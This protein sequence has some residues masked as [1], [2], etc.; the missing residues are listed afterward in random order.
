MSAAGV[1]EAVTKLF[2]NAV[3][4]AKVEIALLAFEELESDRQATRQ[5][6]ALQL[7]RADYEVELARRRYEAADPENRLVA[8]ELEAHWEAALHQREQ[9]R[10][11]REDFERRESQ[12]LSASDRQHIQELSTDLGRVWHAPTT[13]MEERKT[14]LRFLVQRVHLDGVTKP[15]HIRIDVQ[16]HTGAHSTVTIDR[17]LV[18]VWAPKTSPAALERI[19]ELLTGHSYAAIASKLNSEGF[20]TAKG[21]PFND[22]TV[23]YIGAAAAGTGN[24]ASQRV[25]K[26]EPCAL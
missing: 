24:C 23:G 22:R 10:R 5:Q 19:R 7:Q 6:W 18:G 13:S 17:P 26:V 14:L 9:L 25:V 3:T 11:E 16:W 8:A 20:R 2:L 15:G 1:D 4:S 12:A 21:L